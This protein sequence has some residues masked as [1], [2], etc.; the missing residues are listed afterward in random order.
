M[1]KDLNGI[2][3]IVLFVWMVSWFELFFLKRDG[4]VFLCLEYSFVWKKCNE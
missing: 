1:I 2:Y 3:F 4:E